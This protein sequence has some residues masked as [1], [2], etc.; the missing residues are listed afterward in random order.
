MTDCE[1]LFDIIDSYNLQE[2]QT[3]KLKLEILSTFGGQRIYIPK[4]IKQIKS[5]RNELIKDKF[6][7]LLNNGSTCMNAY[8]ELAEREGVSQ[9]QVRYIIAS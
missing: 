5:I 8:Q 1:S 4:S 3:D 9:R 2:V 6:T 7:L